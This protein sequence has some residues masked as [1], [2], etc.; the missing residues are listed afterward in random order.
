M[1]T[2]S[3][4][5]EVD[6]EPAAVEALWY[7]LRRWPSFVDGFAHVAKEE[8]GWPAAGGKLVWDSTARGRGRVV[9]RVSSQDPGEG[10]AVEFEDPRMRGTQEVRFTPLADGTAVAL[11]LDYRLKDAN[12]LTP[13]VDLLFIRRSVR[14]SLRRTLTRFARELDADAD[15]LQ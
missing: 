13:L 14:D 4:Q 2:V 9:E 8:G 5:I 15:L 10:Q 6:A 1:P 12:P 3:A 11:Q 7:D